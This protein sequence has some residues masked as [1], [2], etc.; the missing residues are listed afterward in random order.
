[1]HSQ[2][3]A[4]LSRSIDS[5]SAADREATQFWKLLIGD[6][7]AHF[8]ETLFHKIDI[9][10][11]PRDAKEE[12]AFDGAV[13][14]TCSIDRKPFARLSY[15]APMRGVVACLFL[16]GDTQSNAQEIAGD[17]TN[18]EIQLLWLF[19]ARIFEQVCHKANIAFKKCQITLVTDEENPQSSPGVFSSC[20]MRLEAEALSGEFDLAIAA[21]ALPVSEPAASNLKASDPTRGIDISSSQVSGQVVVLLKSRTL[22]QVE[23]LQTGD[24]LPLAKPS[25]LE[26]RFI[27]RDEPVFEGEIGR[28]GQAYCL[29]INRTT[30]DARMISKKPTSAPTRENMAQ[31][32]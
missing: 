7:G 11:T 16:G 18:G 6:I 29:K 19:S 28:M 15:S 8:R 32:F 12:L 2:I 14:F 10:G 21:H 9:V 27:V 13:T 4:G 20:R 31:A 5:G 1:M 17:L 3:V 30:D 23:L 25:G 26:G 24:V 22:A